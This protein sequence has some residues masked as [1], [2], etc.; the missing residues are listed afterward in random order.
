[1]QRIRR[2]P[3]GARSIPGGRA[4]P[5]SGLKVAEGAL[6]SHR[7]SMLNDSA[8]PLRSTVGCLQKLLVE[9]NLDCLH[10]CSLLN[11]HSTVVTKQL[12]SALV[13]HGRLWGSSQSICRMQRPVRIAQEFTRHQDKIRFARGNNFVRLRWLGDQ[14]HRRA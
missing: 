3:V 5:G 8:C 13:L 6:E 7:E 9:N 14:A 11:T 4:L 12:E 10:I 1:M 2:F